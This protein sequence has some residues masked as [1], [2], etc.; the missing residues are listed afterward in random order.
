MD[1]KHDPNASVPIGTFKATSEDGELE[2]PIE[3]VA[4]DVIEEQQLAITTSDGGPGGPLFSDHEPPRRQRVATLL[5][6]PMPGSAVAG[7]EV[8]DPTRA[9]RR[10]ISAAVD[11][12]LD[13]RPTT[14]YGY[15]RDSLAELEHLVESEMTELSSS[16][17]HTAEIVGVVGRSSDTGTYEIE[18]HEV[19]DS[20]KSPLPVLAPAQFVEARARDA[21]DQRDQRDQSAAAVSSS[22]KNLGTQ[23]RE[24]D[25]QPTAPIASRSDRDR[26]PLESEPP[27]KKPISSL[28]PMEVKRPRAA[29]KQREPASAIGYALVAAMVLLGIGG[30]FLTSG[31]YRRSTDQAAQPTAAASVL[32]PADPLA[33]SKLAAIPE[34][35][36]TVA[37]PTPPVEDAVPAPVTTPA[38][39]GTSRPR[40]ASKT[41][42]KSL[43]A[44]APAPA[45]GEIETPSRDDVLHGL[46]R[47]RSTVSACAEGR[48]G[49]AEVDLTI[50]ANGIVTNAL[51]GGDFGGTP[52][53]S[54]IARAVRKARFPTFKADRYRVLFPY[55][56]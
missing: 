30:W 38:E 42:K 43:A 39:R 9:S 28:A 5:G 2:I 15:K 44:P 16:A 7:R 26:K 11:D 45:F 22:K 25:G 6:V 33:S 36:P 8:A 52:Q 21:R 13:E 24:R 37:E 40:V 4:E 47:V 34:P 23:D 12:A 10:E 54:C 32:R 29:Q 17:D 20:R 49:V 35:A 31:G 51:V 19:P 48:T 27:V 55:V 50:A 41:L 46:D 18:V 3:I 14:I 1:D 56:L 53:G